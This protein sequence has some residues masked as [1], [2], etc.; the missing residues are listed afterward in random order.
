[1]GEADTPS[2]PRLLQPLALKNRLLKH[3]IIFAP[4]STRLAAPD[5]S[6]SPEMLAYYR[7]MASGGAAAV[8]TE[9]FHVD[10]LASKF[11]VV[12]PA[13]HHDR[14]LP[15]LSSL[16][17]AIKNAGALAIAQIGHA[18][19]QS[20]FEANNR[21]PAAPS[22]IPDGPTRDCHELRGKE[23]AQIIQAF[24][25]AAV[26]A[27]VA[28]FDG[29]EIHAGN[30][31][32]INEFL[33]PYTN[34]RSD[35]YGK[36]RELFL[37]QVVEEVSR[38]VG[39]SCI[40]GLRLGCGDFVPGGLAAEEVTRIAGLVP[41]DK[42][43]YVHT[44]AGTK[45]SNDY[46]VQPLYH[47]RAP[48]K[49]IAATI[50][51]ECGIP[52][53]LTGS[54]ND[55]LLA[56]ELLLQK[57][58][59]LI[60]MGRALLAD[61]QLPLKVQ[62][63]A[64]KEIR[65]CIRCNQGCLGRVRQGRTIRCAVNPQLGYEASCHP[66]APPGRTAGKKTVLVAGGGPAGITVALRAAELGFPI[67]L[68]EREQR[69]GGLLNTARAEPFKRDI[70]EYLDYLLDRI[71]RAKVTVIT[72]TTLDSALLEKE[73]PQ[74]LFDATGSVPVLPE[75]P[76]GRPYPVVPVR[77][78]LLSVDRHRSAK[79][80]V[81]LGGGSSGCEA[82]LFLHASGAR[83]TVVEQLSS[84][85]LDLEPV[86]AL[87]LGRLLA[88]TE[89]AIR[90]DTRFLRLGP[91]GVVTDRDDAPLP[92]ELVV[93]A[94]GGRSNEALKRSLDPG[95]WRLGLNYLPVGDAVEVGKIYQAVHDSYW[96][97]TSLLER[98]LWRSHP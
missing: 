93:V 41:R 19:R 33:S 16:V 63:G 91:G 87:S 84:P 76:S 40:L 8:I 17:D 60:G 58:A 88:E 51:R 6:V 66:T 97:A 59:D 73:E 54:V 83:V 53:V 64:F 44:S 70:C 78:L 94:L 38:R 2:P 35:E 79:R 4:V 61:P 50:R 55:P 57:A 72:G 11:T 21:P 3:R 1:M 74:V 75:V 37:L 25:A 56:E 77:E 80:V 98:E 36:H 68:F 14:F 39:P 18:G 81:V 67:R 20:S 92:A 65:P 43:D 22:R 90:T 23:I 95:R 49:E 48:L 30:G 32:L 26:R 89:I 24:A 42:I 28:G 86:S 13:I 47:P 71:L 69:L 82:A 62:R 52:V 46:T 10:D 9:T 5:G 15:G 12:Q 85:L 29:V 96:Q 7:N 34:R 27:L 31:Y 45:E